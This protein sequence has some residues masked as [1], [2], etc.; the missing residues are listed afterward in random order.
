MNIIYFLL[1][2][3]LSVSLIFF[4]AFILSVKS[5]Q[6]DDT[7]TPSVRILFED[8]LVKPNIKIDNKMIH[9]D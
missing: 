1:I 4:L 2:I 6:F 9:D 8:E 5:G 7:H 3:S